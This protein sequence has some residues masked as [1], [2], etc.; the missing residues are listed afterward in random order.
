MRLLTFMMAIK[1]S[2]TFIL[3]FMSTPFLRICTFVLW[4]NE[5][6]NFNIYMYMYKDISTISIKHCYDIG[7]VLL[8]YS[9]ISN[10]TP[11]EKK[12]P[13][14]WKIWRGIKFGGLVV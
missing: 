12:I 8:V 2:K 6:S 10:D 11:S 14:S 3:A 5:N 4:S 13:Y 9:V 7:N 1:C